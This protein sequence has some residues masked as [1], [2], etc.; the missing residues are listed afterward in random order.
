MYKKVLTMAMAAATLAALT[1][2]PASAKVSASTTPIVEVFSGLPI[3]IDEPDS[4]FTCPG[5]QVMTGRS[6]KGDEDGKTTYWCGRVFIDGEAAL[7]QS[8]G[9]SFPQK[10]SSSYFVTSGDQVII[11]R[12][13]YDDENG[14]TQYLTGTL[15]WRGSQVRIANRYWS[16]SVKESGGGVQS[17]GPVVMTGRTHQG[18]ENG[19]TNHEFGWPK[20]N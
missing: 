17:S 15:Y 18:D 2:A 14:K 20:V 3:T 10:E 12:A 13:H 4:L 11:G 9:W 8:E 16:G 19:F 6:H 1:A 5:G 7:V